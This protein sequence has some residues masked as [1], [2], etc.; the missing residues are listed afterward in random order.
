M[1]AAGVTSLVLVD[2]LQVGV[3]IV[4]A[5]PLPR[6]VRLRR[7]PLRLAYFRG[8]LVLCLFLPLGWLVPTPSAASSAIPEF[9]IEVAVLEIA[10]TGTTTPWWWLVLPTLAAGSVW[11]LA[12][13]ATGV[14]SLQRLRD[15]SR[16]QALSPSLEAALSERFRSRLSLWVNDRLG[17]PASF[18]WRKP[19]VIVPRYFAGLSPAMQEA[20]LTHEWLH[21]ER[22]DWPATVFEETVR[23]VL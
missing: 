19:A 13:L 15:S 21:V 5:L 14:R 18:G 9:R 4:L 20:V 17:A 1:N 11:K 10:G 7:P 23:A 8:L 6:L 22:R 3:L 12:R 2:S 16:P